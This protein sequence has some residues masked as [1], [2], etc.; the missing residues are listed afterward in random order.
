MIFAVLSST[1]LCVCMVRL[2]HHTDDPTSAA[3]C[4]PFAGHWDFEQRLR[5]NIESE[6]MS[7]A[8]Q[9]ASKREARE[10]LFGGASHR[11]DGSAGSA[12]VTSPGAAVSTTLSRTDTICS[13]AASPTD[14]LL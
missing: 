8:Q 9:R 13:L 11:R 1:D 7:I 6:K 5:A 4:V 3:A 14:R 2:S 12:A 10:R